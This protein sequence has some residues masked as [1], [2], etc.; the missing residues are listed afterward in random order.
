VAGT[1]A[2]THN[3]DAASRKKFMPTH[4]VSQA[5]LI[6]SKE[7]RFVS[8]QESTYP[9]LMRMC[10]DFDFRV[11]QIPGSSSP[12]QFVLSTGHLDSANDAAMTPPFES[13]LQLDAYVA[14]NQVDILHQYLFGIVEGDVANAHLDG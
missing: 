3:N 11:L 13:L 14:R 12:Q 10:L 6:G 1:G 2:M 4:S 9:Q 5:D 8:R 7:I